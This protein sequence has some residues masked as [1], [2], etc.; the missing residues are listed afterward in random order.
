M[1]YWVFRVD[2]DHLP[3]L[4]SELANGRLRQGWGWTEKQDL[5][6]MTVDEGAGR[7]LR[8]LHEV[9]KGDRLLVPHLP[10]YGK[11]TIVEA[12][13][14]WD[15]G[16]CFRRHPK[17]EDHG[18]VFPAE[19]ITHFQ[20][21]HRSIP[22]AIRSTLRTPSRFWNIDSLRNE[23]D[24]ILGAGDALDE[25]ASPQDR[26]RQ[27]VHE[28]LR[29]SGLRERLSEKVNRYY[30]AGEWEYVLEE[31]LQQL[32]PGWTVER[33]GGRAEAE[34]GTDILAKIPQ[35]G[36]DGFYGV[37]IQ[38]KDYQGAVDHSPVDQLRRAKESDYW[39][40]QGVK[41][42]DLVLAITR[43]QSDLNVS[44]KNYAEEHGIRILWS[45]EIDELLLRAA[46]RFGSVPQWSADSI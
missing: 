32:Y 10:E 41:I 14:D 8:M 31:A 29:E 13:D 20:R 27:T 37:A 4:Q 35:V 15:R 30:E 36:G 28:V 16:Y 38:V 46:A 17:S 25:D 23:V 26:W 3:M 7:N 11:V 2:T 1:R 21:R 24:E 34:H 19:R 42:I 33:T 39:R 40:G 5:R 12:T 22:A 6:N 44:L 18:H 9:K 45:S 43:G